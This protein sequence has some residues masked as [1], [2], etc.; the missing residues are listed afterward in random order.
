MPIHYLFNG[1]N[2]G[3]VWLSS[4]II[5]LAHLG[6]LEGMQKLVAERGQHIVNDRDD[7]GDSALHASVSRNDLDT[8]DY[9]IKQKAQVDIEDGFGRTPLSYA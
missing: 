1:N 8:V 4:T 9:L 7:F 2:N 5:D 3:N 6:Q